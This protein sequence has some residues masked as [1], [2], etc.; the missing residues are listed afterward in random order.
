MYFHGVRNRQH[1]WGLSSPCLF[2]VVNPPRVKSSSKGL[3]CIRTSRQ[4]S[5]CR[6]RLDSCMKTVPSDFIPLGLASIGYAIGD[7]R[8]VPCWCSAQSWHMLCTRRQA[9]K[10]SQSLLLSLF[11][12]RIDR[13]NAWVFLRQCAFPRAELECISPCRVRIWDSENT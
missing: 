8:K 1:L 4:M 6:H 5:R 11:A 10:H 7:C 9:D 3:T 12:K 2:G 13:T